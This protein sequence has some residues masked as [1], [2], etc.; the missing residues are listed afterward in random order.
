MQTGTAAVHIARTAEVA[1]FK[2]VGVTSHLMT[3][4]RFLKLW[5]PSLPSIPLLLEVGGT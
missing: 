2:P 5:T 4:G 1:N 3:G